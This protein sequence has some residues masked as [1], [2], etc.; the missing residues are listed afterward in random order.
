MAPE[1]VRAPR[2]RRLVAPAV[3]VASVAL[4]VAG[5]GAVPLPSPAGSATPRPEFAWS[6]ATIELPDDVV[7]IA[8]GSTPG[9]QC[10]PCHAVQASLMTGVVA[11]GDGFLAV[12]QQLPP[13]EAVA[14]ASR[15]GVT[16]TPEPG[17]AGDEE[18][19]ANAVAVAG[20][21]GRRV[22]VGSHGSAATAWA[23][24]AAGTWTEAPPDVT[25]EGPPGGTAVMRAV[26]AWD[27][28][29]VAVGSRD[30]DADTR[31]AAA[32]TSADGLAWTP[33]PAG[34]TWDGAAAFAVAAS[35]DAV[36]AV[37]EAAGGSI[38][39][40]D[41]PGVAWVMG[42]DGGWMRVDSP[43]FADG[44]LRAVAW[45]GSRFV[46][47]GWS[48]ADDRAMTWT[49]VDGLAWS[50]AASAPALENRGD[51][52]RIYGL[53][54]GPDGSLLAAGW[55]SDAGNGSGVLWTSPDGVAWTRL[56]D[57]VAMSG[58][59]LSGAAFGRTGA[60]V[61]VGTSGYPDNDQ[62]SAWAPVP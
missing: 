33:A 22:I 21:G 26:T 30:V 38:G 25:L 56:P 27:G 31:A 41:G 29:F 24:T 14:Y 40:A 36:V 52:I 61:A 18:T 50:A 45:T 53:A 42:A 28:G 6:R 57:Q 55:K 7:V 4:L 1:P 32:W 51:A 62:A 60:P 19:V 59:S 12:G 47:A 17:F 34:S 37:G 43:A 8:P 13:S 58:A 48:L 44:T 35:A 3:L 2:P 15:D 16:W 49:S 5:C 10:S 23:G 39:T 46:A 9:I 20:D 11:T 54:A